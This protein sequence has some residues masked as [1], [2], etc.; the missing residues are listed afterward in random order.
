LPDFVCHSTISP[1]Y[2]IA[3]MPVLMLLF[4]ASLHIPGSAAGYPGRRATE[5]SPDLNDVTFP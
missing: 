4:L 3:I 1:A 5:L 2:R